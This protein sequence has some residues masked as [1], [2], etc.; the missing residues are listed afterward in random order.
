M[1]TL[2][3]KSTKASLAFG[4]A[5][6]LAAGLLSACS[7]SP[8]A[9]APATVAAKV[10]ATDAKAR[11][12]FF[13]APSKAGKAEA[14][15]L[16]RHQEVT[17]VPGVPSG[18]K[19]QR[20]LFHSRTIYGVDSIQSGYVITPAGKAPSGGW[21]TVAWAHGTSGFGAPCGP[22]K[23]DATGPSGIYLLP[24]LAEFLNAGY[25]V[26]AADYQGLGIAD[27][28]HPYLVG[29]SEGQSVLDAL[30]ASN[31]LLG[32]AVSGQAL[33]YG[34][35]QGGHAALFAAEMAPT[36]APELKLLGVVA[37]APA[38]GMSSL[39]SVVSSNLGASF[40]PFSIPAAWGWVE[41][42]NDLP[43]N[44]LFTQVGAAFAKAQVAKA[45]S[46]QLSEAIKAA[47]VKPTD[48]FNPEA[49]GDAT[50]VAHG[51]L[52]DPGRVATK[53]PML[54]IQGDAD[55]TVPVVLTNAY[56][57]GSACKRGDTISYLQSPTATHGS[58][59]DVG[60][61]QV[62]SWMG[63]RLAGKA[64]PSTCGALGDSGLL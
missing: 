6:A 4:G 58:I 22:S 39:I 52:N 7:S 54:V 41:N 40:M 2:T 9:S 5:L 30:R 11:T 64:A 59:V 27:G 23:F 46:S 61:S 49:G 28:V 45:C 24:K 36:Y 42:Y 26:S 19:V 3:T 15:T 35:S 17:A 12:A 32:S 13:A 10:A 47:E 16:V 60:A 1:R 55:T 21:P 50:V 38:T 37:A 57:S 43:Q 18:A 25:A 8:E 31:H 48:L 53:M 29:K 34:H 56:V 14:G 62:I 44:L 63:D 51:R 20:I 33:I